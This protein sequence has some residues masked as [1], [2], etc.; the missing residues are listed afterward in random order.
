MN[1]YKFLSILVAGLFYGFGLWICDGTY[2]KELVLMIFVIV[3]G[4]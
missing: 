1:L 2:W 3:G 4:S